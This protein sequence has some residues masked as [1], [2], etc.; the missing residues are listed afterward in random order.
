MLIGKDIGPFHIEKELGSGAMGTVWKATYTKTGLPVALKFIAVGL[1]GNEGVLARFEREADILKQLKHPNIVQ[2]Y[3]RGRY[4]GTPF[5]AMEFIHGETLDDVLQRKGR[6]TWEEVVSL[7]RQLCDALQHA[8]D[9]GIIHRDLK[10]SNLMIL[11]DGTLKLTDFG[12]AKD[13]DVT[14]LTGANSTI[15]TAAYMSPEQCRGERHLGSKSDLYSLGVVFFELLTGR[16]PFITDTPMEMLLA[17]VEATP[18]RPARLVPEIPVW[19][20]NLVMQMLEK[21]PD[22]RPLNAAM[23]GQALEEVAEKAISQQSAAAASAKARAIDRPG[24]LDQEDRDATRVIRA[25]AARKKIKAPKQEPIYRRGWF[26]GLAALAFMAAVGGGLFLATRPPSA[27]SLFEDARKSAEVGDAD[28]TRTAVDRYLS[29]YGSRTDEQTGQVREWDRQLLADE[30]QKPLLVWHKKDKVWPGGG[31]PAER[32]HKALKAEE[33]GDLKGAAERWEDLRNKGDSFGAAW[34][35]LAARRLASIGRAREEYERLNREYL[36]DRSTGK[37]RTRDGEGEK[38]AADA[39]RYEGFGDNW[40]ARGLWTKLADELRGD[41]K[42]RE[43][44]LLGA[45]R[46]RDL[47]EAGFSGADAEVADKRR[48]FVRAKLQGARGKDI[49]RTVY[50]DIVSLYADAPDARL[51]ALAVQAGGLA[52]E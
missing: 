40:T 30:L 3:A 34:G 50:E 46:A 6:H 10:P 19:L 24:R 41:I 5:I 11:P 25:G 36:V 20:D 27:T 15:G 32:A 16:K 18:P 43:W 14:A 1:T 49:A 8:H 21:R 31:E 2:L 26:V 52:R 33:A 29:V 44:F 35:Y 28:R 23:V 4:Q 13:I 48:E 9:Q 7:G 45:W 47:K 38:L 12:I 42:G 51:K 39:V 37:V 17:H 22:H